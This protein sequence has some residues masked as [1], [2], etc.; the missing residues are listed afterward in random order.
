MV[1]NFRH[2]HSEHDATSLTIAIVSGNKFACTVPTN[3]PIIL[4]VLLPSYSVTP[5]STNILRTSNNF[6]CKYD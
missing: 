4:A 6:S 2:L 1:N 3:L 5:Q